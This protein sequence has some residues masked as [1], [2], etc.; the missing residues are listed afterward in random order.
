MLVRK[1]LAIKADLKSVKTH[2]IMSYYFVY[3]ADPEEPRLVRVSQ[4]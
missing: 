2:M 3:K 4:K 1:V